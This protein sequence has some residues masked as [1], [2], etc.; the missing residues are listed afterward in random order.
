MLACGW[1]LPPCLR[2]RVFP[3]GRAGRRA[4][5]VPQQPGCQVGRCGHTPVLPESPVWL[6]CAQS[7][8]VRFSLSL[9]PREAVIGGLLH[10][11]LAQGCCFNL[12]REEGSS[13]ARGERRGCLWYL[14]PW[15]NGELSWTPPL[16]PA[17]IHMPTSDTPLMVLWA[18]LRPPAGDGGEHGAACAGELARVLLTQAPAGL[19]LKQP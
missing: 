1:F 9:V 18:R 3:E 12:G 4:G 11:G 6:S 17:C 7:R 16:G 13:Q 19:E 8:S 14:C 5:S 15:G 10:A 2:A